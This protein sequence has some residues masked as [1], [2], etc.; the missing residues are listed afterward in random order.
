MVNP[1]T[2]P[3]AIV[4][5]EVNPSEVK[6]DVKPG[7][8]EYDVKLVNVKVG[9]NSVDVEIQFSKFELK[10]DDDLRVMWSTFYRYKQM[11]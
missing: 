6:N 2:F 9:V 8:V 3:I 1:D 7:D 10:T 4:S 11:V 5:I